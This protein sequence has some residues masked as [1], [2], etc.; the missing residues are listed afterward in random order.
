MVE[1]NEWNDDN[2]DYTYGVVVNR[3]LL[4]HVRGI[5]DGLS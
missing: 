2:S 3:S 1:Q 5:C 4:M